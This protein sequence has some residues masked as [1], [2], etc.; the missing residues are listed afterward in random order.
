M[1][2]KW[3]RRWREIT[4]GPQALRPLVSDRN[5][6]LLI[7]FFFVFFLFHPRIEVGLSITAEVVDTGWGVSMR[8]GRSPCHAIVCSCE[9]FPPDKSASAC[10]VD[11]A[12]ALG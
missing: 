4:D 11:G 3:R 12:V 10:S 6:D 9:E 8:F 5:V 7:L 2:I 1:R